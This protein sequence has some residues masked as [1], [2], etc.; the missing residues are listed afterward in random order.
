MTRSSQSLKSRYIKIEGWSSI[1]LNSLLFILKYWAGIASGSLALIADAW[2]TLTDS[3][4]SVIVLIGGA[5]SR[6]PADQDHPFGH[7]RVEH[8]TAII[9]GV[10]LSIIEIGRASCRERV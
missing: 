8:I 6:K 2:H 9:I 1:L 4:S 3:I 7:G 10:L 5:I